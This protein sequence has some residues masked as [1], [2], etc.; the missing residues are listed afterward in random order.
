MKTDALQNA[1]FGNVEIHCVE[2]N[3]KAD[4][5]KKRIRKNK[6]SIYQMRLSYK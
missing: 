3:G 5:K 1:T 6:C 2:K 4:E